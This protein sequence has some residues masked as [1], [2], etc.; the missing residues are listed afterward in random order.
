MASHVPIRI[1]M[2]GLVLA[3]LQ[4]V[5][6]IGPVE[7]QEAPVSPVP[8]V[9]SHLSG[10]WA[11]AGTLFGRPAEFSMAWE[12]TPGGFVRLSFRNAFA[13]EGS[14]TPILAAEATY[15]FNGSTG[16]GVWVDDRPQQ[17]TLTVAATDTS[18]VANWVAPTEQGRTEY[19]VGR[20]TVRVRDFVGPLE[21]ERMFGEAVYTRTREQQ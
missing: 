17:I 3:S 8:A 20:D 7:A 13:A 4:A 18:L 1:T 19:V 10:S 21:S 15:R 12:T 2:T 5:L 14:T 6:T 9:M 11:G 16:V